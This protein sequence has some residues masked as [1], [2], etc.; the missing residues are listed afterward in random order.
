MNDKCSFCQD[1]NVHSTFRVLQ[2][3]VVTDFV[4]LNDK[5]NM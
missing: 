4:S 2:A 1:K 3:F 5:N